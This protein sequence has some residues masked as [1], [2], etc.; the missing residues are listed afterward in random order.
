MRKS[1][2]LVAAGCL[3]ILA[4]TLPGA[5]GDSEASKG[6][7]ARTVAG[8]LALYDFG[9]T[10]GDIVT[11]RSGVRPPLNLQISNPQAARRTKGA[12][13]IHGKTQILS[14]QQATKIIQA[15]RR[16]GEIT[17]E[18]WVRPSDTG[19]SGPARIVTLSGGSSERN[20]TLGQDGAKYDVRFR[21]TKTNANG[22][23]SLSTD[24]GSVKTDLTHVVYTRD[25]SG[26]TRIYLNGQSIAE[27]KV[28]GSSSKWTRSHKLALANEFNSDRQWKGTYYLVA[29]Y[30]R[31]LS[32]PEVK[33]HFDA[34]RDAPA[35]PAEMAGRHLAQLS[36][37]EQLFET[38]IAP[39]L[40][41]NCLECHNS[42]SKKGRLDLSR[43]ATALAG[44]ESGKVI[45]PGK[46]TESLLWEQVETGDMPPEGQP[47][48]PAEKT[49]LKQWLDAGAIWSLDTIDPAIYTHDEKAG[50]TWVR[51]LTVPEY[52]ETVR[53]SVGVDISKEARE[54]LPPDV[55]AD[56]FSNTAYNLNV[57]LKHVEAYSRLAEIVVG[58]MDVLAFAKRFSKSRSLS[59]D[60]TMRDLVEAMGT[61]LL[62]GPLEER[63][64]TNFSGIATVVASTGGDFKEAVTYIIEAMLQSPRFIYRIEN[65]R[66]DGSVW[67]VSDFEMASRISYIVWGGPPDRELLRAAESSE[68]QDRQLVE[69]Q[70]RRMLEDPR[71]M[72]RSVQFVGEWL[73]LDRLV[74]LR[75]NSKRFPNWDAALG[76]DMRR[77]TLAFF[78]D[79]AWKQKRP[80]ADLL[81]AQF[82]Y[83][84][85]RL[86]QHYDLE[87]QPA[88]DGNSERLTRYDLSSVPARGGLLTQGSVL[89]VG[90]DDASMVTRGLFVLHDLL[91]GTVKDPPPGLDTTPVPA[92]PG[93]SQRRIAEQRIANTA[94]SGCHSKFE[95]LA[96]GLEKF[97]GIGVFHEQDEHGNTLRD[98]GEILF[99]GAAKSINYKSSA[100][101]MDLLADSDRVGASITWKMTQFALGR[102]LVA[103]DAKQVQKIH[104]LAARG[105]GTY[106][107]LL[108]SIV[109]SDLAMMTRTQTE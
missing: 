8:L 24:N 72:R 26:L 84:T 95:P 97:D 37:G 103:Q 7:A 62:R 33:R 75:P 87:V 81:N 14:T 70:V 83:A 63:E 85:P 73:N 40:A 102:P 67:P 22:I 71:A 90:G 6:T 96:F 41:R 56:G 5:E 32:P 80:L 49:L 15:V 69:A 17:I 29:I 109:T 42:A 93:L 10:D 86:A 28:V 18:A 44:G 64:I 99:P 43:K 106:A 12:L 60:A 46:S 76:A 45:V 108:T 94:C 54:I 31:D 3:A 78:E 105:G 65:Q 55:R 107:S 35:A 52:I 51:R 68:L 20:F 100:E 36:P 74:N 39:L 79:V 27:T 59:T 38:K 25:R 98:N 92:K 1:H 57:D 89:T 47:L 34:G 61:L 48:T 30:S 11:D 88:S 4:S 66:G 9:S 53:S 21:T 91:R 77:E 13:E 2:G 50:R 19:L 16:S 58:R 104:E 82:T 101:L 23:P